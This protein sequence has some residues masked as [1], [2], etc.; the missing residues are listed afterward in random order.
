MSAFGG[1]ADV[2]VSLILYGRGRLTFAFRYFR[3]YIISMS[4]NK[5]P[6]NPVPSR[7]QNLLDML[8]RRT[9]GE[10]T[11]SEIDEAKKLANEI[12]DEKSDT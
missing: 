12:R 8:R 3:T 4:D 9:R 2:G 5:K 1:K 7:M 6:D 10:M 11:E